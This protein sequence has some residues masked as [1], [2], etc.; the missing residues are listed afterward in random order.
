MFKEQTPKGG[1]LNQY[2]KRELKEHAMVAL[3]IAILL[4]GYL[5]VGYIERGM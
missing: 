5:S 2:R 3:L 1:W 4:I